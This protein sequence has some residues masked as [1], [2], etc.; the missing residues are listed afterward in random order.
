MEV[1]RYG[2][3]SFP[4]LAAD[5]AVAAVVVA[6]AP[7]AAVDEETL[8]QTNLKA[9]PNCCIAETPRSLTCKHSTVASPLLSPSW[10]AAEGPLASLTECPLAQ[11]QPSANLPK[12]FAAAAAVPV[13][14]VLKRIGHPLHAKPGS[15]Q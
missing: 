5:G 15:R 1:R 3:V 6:V 8:D 12:S 2:P 7:V 11:S 4:H 13:S 10:T 9:L 14:L